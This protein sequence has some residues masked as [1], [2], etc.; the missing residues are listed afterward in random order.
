MHGLNEII[1]RTGL[2][3]D[4]NEVSRNAEKLRLGL[5]R[6]DYFEI[7]FS[8]SAR[9]T[10]SPCNAAGRRP[11][12]ATASAAAKSPMWPICPR[13]KFILCREG[14]EGDFPLRYE[15]GTIGLM[16]VSGGRIQK[17]DACCAA[18]KA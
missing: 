10:R 14:A 17:A 4:Y 11:K 6:A 8:V 5:T 18:A 13:A 3:V 2:A 15:D 12:R 1:L 9:S 16:Q 7:D